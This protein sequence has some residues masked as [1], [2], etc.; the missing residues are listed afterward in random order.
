MMPIQS[1]QSLAVLV[2]SSSLLYHV[3]MVEYTTALA[4]SVVMIELPGSACHKCICSASLH[5]F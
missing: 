4:T 5:V 1:V 2:E 3:T